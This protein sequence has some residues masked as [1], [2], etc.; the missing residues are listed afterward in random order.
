M[1]MAINT[2]RELYAL[3]S[4]AARYERAVTKV[5]GLSVLIY[6]KGIKSFV[7]RYVRRYSPFAGLIRYFSP[8]ARLL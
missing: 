3:K 6:P 1:T 2:D 4:E 5:R 8:V 7:V